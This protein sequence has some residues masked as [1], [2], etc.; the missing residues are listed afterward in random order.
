M[1]ESRYWFLTG[2]YLSESLTAEEKTELDSFLKTSS[3]N[4]EQFDYH[5]KLW[6]SFGEK[7]KDIDFDSQ[8]SW[9]ELKM[10]I[11]GNEMQKSVKTRRLIIWRSI[12]AAVLLGLITTTTLLIVRY[13]AS[14]I[15]ISTTG[16]KQLFILPDSTHVWLNRNSKLSYSPDFND[17]TRKVELTGEAYFE[18]HHNAAK[19]FII[20]SNRTYT[21]VLGTKFDVSGYEADSTVVVSVVQGK[22]QFGSVNSELNALILTKNCTGTFMKRSEG[23]V[24]TASE[25]PNVMAWQT[26]K[27]VFDNSPLTYLFAKLEKFYN[28]EIQ[29]KSTEFET[30]RFTGTFTDSKLEEIFTVLEYTLNL[31]FTKEGNSTYS[32]IGQKCSE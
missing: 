10:R 11:A 15:V 29:I 26:N 22:V 20:N 14:P 16:E 18:V 17:K 31:K 3:D 27:L 21:K 5:I 24:K 1:N 30:C 23:L 13:K 12:A 25:D 9:I 8:S 2:K 7:Q 4:Q 32:V 19:P 6:K 28:I